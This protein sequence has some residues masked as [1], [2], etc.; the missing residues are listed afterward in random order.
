MNE[1][2]KRIQ[3][4]APGSVRITRE[5]VLSGY[6]NNERVQGKG[7]TGYLTLSCWNE[8]TDSI[9]D[10]ILEAFETAEQPLTAVEIH[11]SILPVRPN[12]RFSSIQS[13]LSMDFQRVER[14]LYIPT[15]WQERYKTQDKQ[16]ADTRRGELVYQ[17]WKYLIDNHQTGPVPISVA[18]DYFRH[19]VGVSKVYAYQLPKRLDIF[20][21]S[22]VNGQ[23]YLQANPNYPQ[24]FATG[25]RERTLQ[26]IHEQLATH[27]GRL[28]L[29]RLV[30]SVNKIVGGNKA[31]IY[32]YISESETL[33]KEQVDNRTFVASA[34]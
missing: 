22:E 17:C 13:M 27:G 30:V 18:Y 10:L 19:K 9:K 7:K 4:Q 2:N 32:K 12:I 16:E 5:K 21:V 29:R 14:G 33:R 11:R 20:T 31:S 1:L 26:V 28:P 23:R 3:A 24:Q 8:N 25:K 34:T 15:A 6:L